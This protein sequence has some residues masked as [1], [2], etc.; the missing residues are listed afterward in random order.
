MLSVREDILFS[1]LKNYTN[2]TSVGDSSHPSHR[3]SLGKAMPCIAWMGRLSFFFIKHFLKCDS[4][5]TPSHL[6]CDSVYMSSHFRKSVTLEIQ[7]RI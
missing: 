2:V 4:I 7:G 3:P 6:K 5:Y 1:S